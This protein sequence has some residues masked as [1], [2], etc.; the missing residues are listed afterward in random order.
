[1]E[2]GL[3]SAPQRHLAAPVFCEMFLKRTAG[4]FCLKYDNFCQE[5]VN[6][7]IWE[8]LAVENWST[9]HCS[10][11]CKQSVVCI[12]VHS[13]ACSTEASGK[14][15]FVPTPLKGQAHC[16]TPAQIMHGAQLQMLGGLGG[17]GGRD[18]CSTR[19]FPTLNPHA[20]RR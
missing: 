3:H 9:R 8:Y 12:P 10:E 19:P 20:N 14:F 13:H 18:A 17:L 16:A 15:S 6:I 5:I 2:Y 11:H 1:M 4:L 7:S